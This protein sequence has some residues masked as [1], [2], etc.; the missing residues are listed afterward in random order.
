MARTHLTLAALATAAVPGL[1]VQATRSHTGA[2]HGEYDSAVLT[3]RDGRE[4]IV[5]MPRTQ[6]AETEQAADLVALRAL[7][8]GV[9]S[10]LPFDVPIYLGQAPINGTRAL[11]YDFLP[12]APVSLDH[13]TGNAG[14]AASVGRSIAAIHSLPTAFILDAGL[15]QQTAPE[16]RSATITLIGRAADTGRLPAALLRRWEE[17]TDDDALWQFAP[18]VING[19]L[20]SASLLVSDNAVSAVIGWS[21]LRVGD[22]ARDLH[23]LLASRGEAAETAIAAYTAARGSAADRLI[24][25]RAMLYAELELARWLLHGVDAHDPSIVDDAVTMLDGLVDS[26]HSDVMNPISPATGPVLAVSDV[27]AM[28]DSTPRTDMRRGAGSE[29]HTDSYDQSSF[30]LSSY[31]EEEPTPQW[32]SSPSGAVFSQDDTATGP[33]E[34]FAMPPE[35]E[36]DDSEATDDHS[37]R[38]S[39]SS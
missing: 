34:L 20:G 5:R 29:M 8:T 23:W 1:D 39:S 2:G 9:R 14:L 33:I 24:T 31:G 6:T 10:R 25:R 21:G 22:G 28:L 11:A 7:T 18:V 38:S 36:D 12:G 4:V 26:V 35:D 13:L 32:D 15:P 16:A 3:D 30:E 17:A 19:S 37:S 27:E